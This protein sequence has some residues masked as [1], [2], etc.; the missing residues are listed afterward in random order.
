MNDTAAGTFDVRVNITNDSNI[1]SGGTGTGVRVA[2]PLAKASITDNDNSITNNGT[3]VDVDGGVALLQGNNL[4]GNTI[5][6]LIQNGGKADLGQNGPGSNF[7][8]LG[9]STGGNDFSGYTSAAT[10][11]SGAIVNLNTNAPNDLAGRQ[12][13]PDD[14][15]AF[16]NTWAVNTAAGIENVIFH[17]V[18]DPTRGFVDYAVFGGL[19][20]SLTA[21]NVNEGSST[22]VN[23]SFTD[24][25]APHTVTINWG[26]GSPDTVVNLSAGVANFS[27]PSPAGVTYA[28]DP[29]GPVNSINYSISVTVE[30]T[31]S[32]DSLADNSLGVTVSNVAPTIA[33][34]G[35]ASVNEGSVYTLNL[36]AITD[37][38]NDTVTRYI[39]N[40]GDGSFDDITANPAN[41]VHMHTYDDGTQPRNVTISLFDEDASPH[42][43]TGSPDP[44][45][46]TVNNVAPTANFFSGG[47]V[48][49]GSNGFVGFGAQFDPSTADTSAGFRYSYD[50]NNDGDFTDAG[51]LSDVTNASVGV[52]AVY[53][54]DGPGSRTVRARI[55]DKDGGFTDYTTSIT[56][57]NVTPFVNGGPD[58]NVPA[59]TSWSQ[60]GTFSDPGADSPWT[61][62]V[63]YDISDANPA[64][65]LTLNGF[66]FTL[67]NVYTVPGTYTIRVTVTD[68]DG[69]TGQDDVQ[70]TV[71]PTPTFQV[72]QFLVQS[73]GF[74]LRFN[75]AVDTAD[76][77]LYDGLFGT[78]PSS[79]PADITLVGNTVGAVA[80]S[81][82][83]DPVNN[84]A[85]FVRTGGPLAIDTYT[86]TVRSANNAF[87]DTL[88]NLLDG[89]ANGTG[90][91]DFVQTFNVGNPFQRTLSIPDF[92]RG[93]DTGSPINVPNT[94]T[95]G[96]PVRIDDG[97][98]V[99]SVDFRV[100]YDP[101]LLNIT[102]AQLAAGMPGDW[103]I[104]SNL[105]T[106]GVAIITVFGTSSDLPAG[107]QNIVKLIA[108]VPSNAPYGAAG[109]LRLSNLT[110][111]KNDASTLPTRGDNGVHK[112]MY[113][114]D[115]DGD[116]A[117]TGFDAGLISRVVVNADSGFHASPLVDPVILADIDGSAALSGIDASFVA[118]KAALLP[119]PEIPD[120][121]G[122]L[123]PLVPGGVDPEFST[124]D[125][126]P[127]RP[128]GTVTMPINIDDASGTLG[129]NL[130]ID[131]DT[132]L[133]DLAN[134][135]VE[136]GALYTA[137]GGWSLVT[138]VNEST[139]KAT[140]VFWRSSG[141]PMPAG[142][143]GGEVARATFTVNGSATNNTV[144]P[145][146]L[147]GNPGA[148]GLVFTFDDGSVLVDA[149][150]PTVLADNYKYQTAP[151]KLE[152]TF[153]EDVAASLVSG[154]F[155]VHNT[156]TNTTIP[157]SDFT[158]SYDAN[159]NVAT[160]SYIPS[161][162]VLP[163]GN[164]TVSVTAADVTDEAGNPLAANFGTTFFFL[165]AD[166]DHDGR[167]NLNDF[168][169]LA[170]NFGQS[171]R[172]FTQADFNYD[173]VVNLND[174]N[175]LAARFGAALGPDG[176]ISSPTGNA[177]GLPPRT[178]AGSGSTDL[179]GGSTGG[180]SDSTSGATGSA[181]T[182]VGS[183]ATGATTRPGG[184]TT[185]TTTTTTASTSP[186]S[187]IGVG[188]TAGSSSDQL[189]TTSA[190][191]NPTFAS[192]LIG[193]GRLR[194][195]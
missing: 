59:N 148:S 90:G 19:A 57:F 159:T 23:G 73:S 107:P 40:W 195:S 66:N 26:D 62:T 153:S 84:I 67:G 82:V 160:L 64:V 24:V 98:Q 154:D 178:P 74:T 131:Y 96:L 93:P 52:P 48:P 103:S 45:A 180:S 29:N 169:I 42:F 133:L 168:N 46:V 188:T 123:P 91:D 50:F 68:K 41:T 122:I 99:R 191:T 173:G 118:Q 115:A 155:V 13:L 174:F 38:G 85:T 152:F 12:G 21:T 119:R 165:M 78:T 97:S 39:I 121:P 126:K 187:S 147:D 182:S 162:G 113:F 136:L 16:G 164:Y 27:I 43:N 146:E 77:N 49:E 18:D 95:L 109:V 134:A 36:G 142:S 161:G 102:A 177:P 33:V 170:A 138:N 135:N 28:D 15:P 88:G 166:A 92:A 145:V 4:G 108:N 179:T 75:R 183:S 87:K 190:Y 189:V 80:G 184:T 143:G 105:S 172:D 72:N 167:V 35:G 30:Q 10:T 63:D 101:A 2:G 86:L 120:L 176:S 144:I 150:A 31:P 3:G 25:A 171:P 151:H 79:E 139:G 47:P 116:R 6:V 37:P 83:W 20:V 112:V 8:G 76:L 81:V 192:Q 129:Y 54:N 22:T 125:N 137:A 55:K 185:T 89:D 1:S 194:V 7:T 5:G 70:V 149:V 193:S 186:F 157:A 130:T 58:V 56:I 132:N 94:G 100:N 65:P 140:L 44:F 175:I 181:G 9:I 60:Q 163:D 114:G 69:A 14:V 17:D 128:G 32:G 124:P 104:T 117:Y 110:V 106:P 53:L 61:A 156:T 111:S 11:T 127:A 34:S 158:L 71:G 51:E 141:V